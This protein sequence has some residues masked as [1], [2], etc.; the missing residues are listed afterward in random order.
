[1]T[2]AVA[3]PFAETMPEIVDLTS[4]DEESIKGASEASPA[5]PSHRESPDCNPFANET[6]DD[7]DSLYEEILRDSDDFPYSQSVFCPVLCSIFC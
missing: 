6:D 3:L 4:S 2:G 5:S 7:N 1:M